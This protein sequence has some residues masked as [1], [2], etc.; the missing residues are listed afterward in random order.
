MKGQHPLA[1]AFIAFAAQM[2]LRIPEPGHDYN[3]AGRR[4]KRHEKGDRGYKAMRQYAKRY[5]Y[6]LPVGQRFI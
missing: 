3:R 6:T 4:A 1:A 5:G 2:A